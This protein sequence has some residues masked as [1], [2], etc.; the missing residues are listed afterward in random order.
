M[1]V[2]MVSHIIY[3]GIVQYK[4]TWILDLK[5]CC[6]YLVETR[7]SYQLGVAQ[8]TKTL[9]GGTLDPCACAWY[10]GFICGFLVK[11]NHSL[12]SLCLWVLLTLISYGSLSFICAW[13]IW[14]VKLY[15]SLL[16]ISSLWSFFGW[17][18]SFTNHYM[19]T[20]CL[21]VSFGTKP[22]LMAP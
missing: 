7:V 20:Y 8:S 14:L 11:K 6:L 12:S 3:I 21:M 1:H 18:E 10:W 19:S 4:R 15:S 2:F 22:I 5:H 13:S 16:V 17:I 9:I